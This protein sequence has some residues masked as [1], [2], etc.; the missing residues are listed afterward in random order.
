MKAVFVSGWA[1]KS[2]AMRMP[3]L[4][5]YRLNSSTMNG[6]YSS[7]NVWISVAA[8]PEKPAEGWTRA[9]DSSVARARFAAT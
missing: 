2:P 4:I 3:P 5:V 8:A 7:A 9:I 6:M 1:G